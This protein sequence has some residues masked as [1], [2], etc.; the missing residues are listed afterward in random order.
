MYPDFAKYQINDLDSLYNFCQTIEYGWIDHSGNKHHGVNDS[1]EYFLQ[2]PAE[3][4][5][6][7]IG[8]CWDQ[9]ELQR[10]WFASQGIPHETY[11]LYYYLSDDNCPSHSILTFTHHGKPSWFEPMFKNTEVYYAGIHSYDSIEEL[12]ANLRTKF[13]RNGQ[14]SGSLPKEFHLDNLNLYRYNRPDYG[15]SCSE[16]YEHCRQGDKITVKP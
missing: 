6:N 9:T 13:I 10:A 8:I 14:A 1:N 15:I 7:Q 12:L 3:V 4:L 11:F 2:S 5:R 16:F